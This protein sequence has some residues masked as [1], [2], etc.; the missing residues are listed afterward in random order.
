[1]KQHSGL[2]SCHVDVHVM[3]GTITSPLNIISI[4]DGLGPSNVLGNMNAQKQLAYLE[5][6]PAYQL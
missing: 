2:S 3:P 5:F 4:I 1:M 6:T